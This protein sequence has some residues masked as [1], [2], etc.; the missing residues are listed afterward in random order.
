MKL[1]AVLYLSNNRFIYINSFNI[2]IFSIETLKVVIYY[3]KTLC[4][5]LTM[6]DSLLT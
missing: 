3:E 6:R 4:P 2:M 1:V 5:F